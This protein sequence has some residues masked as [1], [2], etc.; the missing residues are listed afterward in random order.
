MTL[1]PDATNCGVVNPGALVNTGA[2]TIN[3]PTRFV[4]RRFTGVVTNNSRAHFYNCSFEPTGS[5]PFAYQ[6]SNALARTFMSRCDVTGSSSSAMSLE[7]GVINR[8]RIYNNA[9]NGIFLAGQQAFTVSICGCWIERIGQG[10]A[11]TADTALIRAAVGGPFTIRGNR[12][13]ANAQ[14]AGYTQKA[15]LSFVSTTGNIT[16]VLVE[17]NF[18]NGGNYTIDLVGNA[19]PPVDP[20]A[21]QADDSVVGLRVVHNRFGRQYGT[22]PIILGTANLYGRENRWDDTGELIPFT[23]TGSWPLNPNQ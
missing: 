16:D 12:L 2:T 17:Y 19:P 4:N 18:L 20:C 23:G 14:L 21:A 1:F 5:P 15:A 3:A 9:G 7:H 10:A 11:P 6:G 22:G 13:D 8:C